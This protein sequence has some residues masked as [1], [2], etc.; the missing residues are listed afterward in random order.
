[1]PW[2]D[3]HTAPFTRLGIVSTVP[4]A[5]GVFG[6]MQGPVCLLVGES[7]NLKARLLDLVN[8]TD[9][10]DN[11]GVTYELCHEDH[12]AG[13]MNELNRELTLSAEAVMAPHRK[14]PGICGQ[15]SDIRRSA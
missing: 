8:A 11:L 13:R 9:S 10:T 15:G 7:W 6:I 1:M 4:S 2:H 12:R 14:L 5:S 3:S